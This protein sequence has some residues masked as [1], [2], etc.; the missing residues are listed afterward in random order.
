MTDCKSPSGPSERSSEDP[1]NR[2]QREAERGELSVSDTTT[3]SFPTVG[4]H[5]ETGSNSRQCCFLLM[6]KRFYKTH[7]YIAADQ[8]LRPA[9]AGLMEGDEMGVGG[10]GWEMFQYPLVVAIQCGAA[11]LSSLYF[12]LWTRSGHILRKV[13][14]AG[15]ITSLLSLLALLHG[16]LYST[17]ETPEQVYWSTTAVNLHGRCPHGTTRSGHSMMD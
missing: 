11:T 14:S 5:T 1:A 16:S 12:Y 10:G 17:P 13:C 3:P 8:A 2:Q 15:L 9:A 7:S 6:Q 4:F